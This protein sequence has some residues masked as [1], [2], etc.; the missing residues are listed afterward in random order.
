MER[1]LGY[2]FARQD[3]AQCGLYDPLGRYVK[4][5][6]F[7]FPFFSRSRA[8]TNPWCD[9]TRFFMGG[10]QLHAVQRATVL[11]GAF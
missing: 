11:F 1:I 8:K 9:G 5:C 2:D 10:D 3:D 6:Y 4:L 7:S